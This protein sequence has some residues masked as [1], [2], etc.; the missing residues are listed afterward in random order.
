VFGAQA[1]FP[2][3]SVGIE[4]RALQYRRVA[5][6]GNQITF[7]FCPTCGSTVYYEPHAEPDLVAVAVGAF[8]DS[9]FPA[10]TVSVYEARKHEWVEVPA[11]VDHFD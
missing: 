2:K 11:G 3:D 1:R 8:A 4:G 5:D 7:F 10:P 9:A 6:S